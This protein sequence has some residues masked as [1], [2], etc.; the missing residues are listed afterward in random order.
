MDYANFS[1]LRAL[2]VEHA[3]QFQ[4]EYCTHSRYWSITPFSGTCYEWYLLGERLFTR[5]W[6][7]T[8]SKPHSHEIIIKKY[9][10]YTVLYIFS[11]FALLYNK[12]V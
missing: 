9:V 10:H 6:V 7:K 1:E 2:I 5:L 12:T 4:F 11:L 8:T 3:M